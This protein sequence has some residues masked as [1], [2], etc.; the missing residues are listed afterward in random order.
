MNIE[1]KVVILTGS[2]GLLGQAIKEYLIKNK[3][4][5]ICL[6]I[7]NVKKNQILNTL[8]LI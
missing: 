1:K 3:V 7:K 5:L 8:K 4:K 6:D 2:E